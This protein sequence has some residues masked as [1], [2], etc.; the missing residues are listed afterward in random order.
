[1]SR[2]ERADFDERGGLST[3]KTVRWILRLA[4][5]RWLNR[6]ASFFSGRKRDPSTG[7]RRATPGKRRWTPF[8]FLIAVPLFVF[9][10]VLLSTQIIRKLSHQQTLESLA[11]DE[12]PV[13]QDLFDE[14]EEYYLVHADDED[15]P[16][17]ESA[18]T[19]IE[20]EIRYEYRRGHPFRQDEDGTIVEERT[21]E[22]LRALETRGLET[23]RVVEPE[24]HWPSRSLWPPEA[25]R[26]EFIGKIAIVLTILMISLLAMSVGSGNKD[27]GAMDGHFEWLFSFPVSTRGVFLAKV[28]EYSFL[29]LLPWFLVGPFSFTV[30]YCASGRLWESIAPAV[31]TTIYLALGV[32]CARLAIETYLRKHASPARLKSLQAS[33]T[34]LSVLSLYLAIYLGV[35]SSELPGWFV[36]IAKGLP[37]EIRYLPWN[38]PLVIAEPLPANALAAAGLVLIGIIA[39]SVTVSFCTRT[40]ESGLMVAGGPYQG[41]REARRRSAS[42]STRA[43]ASRPSAA[44]TLLTK[45]IRL[46]ARDRNFFVQTIIMPV[47]IIGFQIIVNPTLLAQASKNPRHAAMLAF[48]IGAY[49]LAFGAFQVLASETSSL[50]LLNTFPRS[51]ASLLEIKTVLWALVS[52][53]YVVAVLAFVTWGELVWSGRVVIDLVVTVVGIIVYA[54]IATGLGTLATSPEAKEAT[55]RVNP[56][57]SML[58]MLL[59]SLYAYAIYSPNVW[60]K[61]VMLVLC[62]LVAF[63]IWQKVYDHVPYLLDRTASPK[64]RV[65]VSEGLIACL[66]FFVLQGLLTMLLLEM[67]WL[68]SPVNATAV[69]FTLAGGIVTFSVLAWGRI[70]RVEDFFHSLGLRR[71]ETARH[72]IVASIGLGVAAGSLAGLL[73]L[74][75][76]A[77]YPKLLTMMDAPQRPVSLDLASASQQEWLALAILTIVAAPAVEEFLF[78]GMIFGGLRQ[79][80]R[81]FI[82]AL[83]SAAIF[84]IVHPLPSVLPVF[85]LGLAAATAFQLSGLL[86]APIV[87][88][89]VYNAIVFLAQS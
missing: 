25:D 83:M 52:L 61:V 77:L 9:Q 6:F 68:H 79:R 4:G 81:W 45:E 13:D 87:C 22:I 31:V 53:A 33:F 78:R 29:S 30:F 14:L 21:A 42:T 85:G 26:D 54:R 7:K 17:T 38:L 58:Y 76:L 88:H 64:A 12:I 82:A 71:R 5:R 89:A 28:L 67:S 80:F 8:V 65:T 16:R 27:L 69:A 18:R 55:R 84:A 49:V 62:W 48:G 75:Y 57:L 51:L 70:G 35:S 11:P 44:R 20:N 86:V 74:A 66:C 37:A 24:P 72:G 60:P 47:L 39:A 32:G 63:A 46:L 19:R 36:Q 73:G 56:G 10:G 34:M 1:M 41:S 2:L 15:S 43:A 3:S 59:A 23:F 40:V 50:W